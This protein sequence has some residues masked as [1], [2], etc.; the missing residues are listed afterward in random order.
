[1]LQT[2]L[3]NFQS[4]RCCS[5]TS[6]F[7]TNCIWKRDFLDPP[8]SSREG[9]A[10]HQ[11]ILCIIAAD[12]HMAHPWGA[13]GRFWL[14]VGDV[15]PSTSGPLVAAVCPQASGPGPWWPLYSH[16]R[17]SS[18]PITLGT[19][20]PLPGAN[21]NSCTPH[22][23][24]QC[25]GTL[26]AAA[27]LSVLLFHACSWSTSL[28]RRGQ[29]QAASPILQCRAAQLRRGTDSPGP[30]GCTCLSG[31]FYDPWCLPVLPGFPLPPKLLTLL[32]NYIKFDNICTA[33][34]GKL[35]ILGHLYEAC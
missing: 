10:D 14:F 7:P 32:H 21:R 29:L 22:P 3:P 4:F 17:S 30:L 28:V 31:W 15:R 1:M 18:G 33:H 34:W 12:S 11:G 25:R 24:P 2:L 23:S 5:L 35:E 8:G 19:T 20:Y 27:D 26:E 6:R 9:S 16:S 13:I